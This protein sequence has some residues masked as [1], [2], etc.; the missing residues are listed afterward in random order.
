M[1]LV[2]TALT[3]ILALVIGAAIWLARNEHRLRATTHRMSES[4]RRQL[5]R[6][7]T[8]RW[9]GGRELPARFFD[10][11]ALSA[12]AVGVAALCGL[13]ALFA[14]VS[15][16][17]LDGEGLALVDRPI[18]AWLAAHRE[19]VLTTVMRTVTMVGSPVAVA[20]VITIV[21]TAVAWRTRTGLPLVIAVLAVA[22]FAISVT[23]AK[24]VIGRQRPPLSYAVMALDGYSY[25]SGHVIGVTIAAGVCAW[26]LA[27]RV[28]RSGTIRIAVWTTALVIIGGVGFSRV[29][30]GVHY[31]SDVV[32]GWLLGATWTGVVIA[33]AALWQHARRKT[34]PK[35]H[36]TTSSAH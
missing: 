6:L 31:P 25:P 23:V 7:L 29:Y 33:Y 2:S 16:N 34:R 1:G 10:H 30:L 32:G 27:H 11:A 19:P 18:V 17:V 35:H 24:L 22:G 8:G 4:A 9:N 28:I 3:L 5:A 15:D 36:E 13:A 14:K 21:C 26:M 20:A 12:L